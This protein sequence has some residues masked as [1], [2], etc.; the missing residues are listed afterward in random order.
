MS[1]YQYYEFQAIDRP[2]TPEEQKAVASLS[3]RVEPHPRRA[4]FVYHYSDFRGSARELLAEYYDAFFYIAN[5]GTVRLGFRFPKHLVDYDEIQP[6]FIDDYV[7]GEVVGDYILVEIRMDNEEGFGWTEGEGYLDQLISL[8]DDILRR[9]YR[10]LYLGWLSALHDEYAYEAEWLE[11][12]VPAGLQKL[13]PALESFVELFEVDENL[14]GAAARTSGRTQA[15]ST[16]RD[17]GKAIEGMSVADKDA[18][19]LRLAQNEAHLGL[20]FQKYLSKSDKPVSSGT[21]RRTIEE[22]LVL[23]EEK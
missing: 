18:W 16:K 14:V 1:E 12:P 22:L 8:R 3:S 4:I 11:P 20:V 10:V 23:A 9:D 6:Y 2:L 7:T 17:F 21:G 15:K 19:L 5:W 13:T